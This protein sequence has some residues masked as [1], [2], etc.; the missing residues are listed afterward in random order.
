[1]VQSHWYILSHLTLPQRRNKHNTQSPEDA[2]LYRRQYVFEQLAALYRSPSS[3]SASL[4][5]PIVQVTRQAVR[6]PAAAAHLIRSSGLLPFLAAASAAEA[7][8]PGSSSAA[9]EA[10]RGALP[11][12]GAGGGGGGRDAGWALDCM[13]SLLERRV[14]LVHREHAAAAFDG[15]VQAVGA[16][17]A[18][19]AAADAPACVRLLCLLARAAPGR[20]ELAVVQQLLFGRAQAAALLS[21]VDGGSISSLSLSSSSGSRGGGGLSDSERHF[22]ALLLHLPPPSAAGEQRPRRDALRLAEWASGAVLLAGPAAPLDLDSALGLGEGSGEVSQGQGGG[23]G[24]QLI[25]WLQKLIGEDAA[26]LLSTGSDGGSGEA[27]A[28]RLALRAW[29]AYSGLASPAKRAAA[30]PPLLQLLAALMSG[31]L[32]RLDK[33]R[34]QAVA[35]AVERAAAGEGAVVGGGDE[36]GWEA[37]VLALRELAAAGGA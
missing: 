5:L 17:V 8:G 16:V 4:D 25:T 31:R 29:G 15:Y 18:R 19:A 21:A 35:R 24:L 30:R 20:R 36:D 1:M 27:D 26:D 7:E 32:Q 3:E 2:R 14:G 10:G 9:V 6:L 34:A 23:C 12:V 37:A 22:L 33:R 13:A 28:S 11:A